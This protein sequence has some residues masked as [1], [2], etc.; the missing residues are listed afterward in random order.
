ME[1]TVISNSTYMKRRDLFLQDLAVVQS[2]DAIDPTSFYGVAYA[3]Y[4]LL[5]GETIP[6]CDWNSS[7]WCGYCYHILFPAWHRSYGL[8]LEILGL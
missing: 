6:S 2:R 8:L 1:K 5:P 3:P 7:D 4:D